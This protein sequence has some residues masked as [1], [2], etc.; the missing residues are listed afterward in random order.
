MVA[1]EEARRRVL[2]ACGEGLGEDAGRVA[3]A[4]FGHVSVTRGWDGVGR[5]ETGSGVEAPGN[6]AVDLRR[7]L[8]G[9]AG[10][11]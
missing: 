7:V 10:T 6:R 2:H 8:V 3:S 4:R 11:P 1:G 5:S 9:R